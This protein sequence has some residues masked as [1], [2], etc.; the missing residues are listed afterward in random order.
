MTGRHQRGS[1]G[2]D[3]ERNEVDVKA[4][5]LDRRR[6]LSRLIWKLAMEEPRWRRRLLSGRPGGLSL[7]TETVPQAAS[8]KEYRPEDDDGR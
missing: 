6:F 2:A 8:G 1:I 7:P 3:G 5:F 4:M